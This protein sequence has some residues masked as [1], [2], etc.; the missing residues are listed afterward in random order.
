MVSVKTGPSDE[1]RLDGGT[2]RVSV[3]A[4]A[5]AGLSPALTAALLGLA[6]AACAVI[7]ASTW[8][9]A[10]WPA[11]LYRVE[12][13]RS[14]GWASFDTGW[15]GGHYP[16]A[17][18][19][20]FPVLASL[21]G[22]A[23][24]VAVSIAGA[25]WA[26]DSLV[27]EQF[28]PRGRVGTLCF[29]GGALL[30]VSIGQLPFLL[31]AQFALLAFVA[32]HRHRTWL[33][34]LAAV[35]TPL[36]SP[37][38]AVFAVLAACVWAVTSH[39][40]R[41]PALLVAA[42]AL[43]PLA[44]TAFLWP[45]TGR[46]PFTVGQF[47]LVLGACAATYA[48]NSH[49]ALRTGAVLYAVGAAAAFLIPS[50]IGGNVGRL[51]LTAGVPLVV[52]AV[53]FRPR[54]ILAFAAV[55]LLVW[56]WMPF[57]SA[58]ASQRDPSQDA[59]YFEPLLAH[60]ATQQ[61]GPARIEIPFT[62][63]HWEAAS[64]APT[65]PLAR[66]WYRQLDTAENGLFY[67]TEPLTAETYHAWLIDHGVSWVALPDVPLDFSYQAEAELLRS[68]LPYL[69][70]M[71]Q[72]IHWRLWKVLDSPGLVTGPARLASMSADRFHLRFSAAG[73]ATV[74]VRYTDH[75]DVARGAA[76]V[77]PT[78]T[79]WTTV[80]ADKPGPVTVQAALLSSEED[81]CPP[82]RNPLLLSEV[83]LRMARERNAEKTTADPVLGALTP[84]HQG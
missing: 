34:F 62:R 9:G 23:A 28:G 55:P 80:R 84:A 77:G 64:V 18:S 13:F 15:Y 35:V 29:A 39:E 41:R 76:C 24:V 63:D 66:G 21:I 33:A 17:Y 10:D 79:G 44:A 16:L 5:R 49:R 50:P 20:L 3:V 48:L 4:P 69:E 14:H 56:Q 72:N 58:V 7:V 54:Q 19:V 74:R 70:P 8:R 75:W 73:V 71:W 68:G 83:A 59:T 22:P 65:F 45:Q 6:T 40:R 60:L 81:R 42:G 38:A 25:T 51:A 78:A 53:A 26:F 47:L 36:A 31:G 32:L 1:L 67:G 82:R 46:F 2:A 43:V 30:N 11:Q 52:A 27:Y 57:V 12:F 61:V 37:V